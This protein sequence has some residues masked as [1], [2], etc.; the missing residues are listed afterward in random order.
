MMD[1]NKSREQLLEEVKE[2]RQQLLELEQSRKGS[3]NL[4]Q[5]L[6]TEKI[7]SE[8]VMESLPGIFYLF[9]EQGNMIRWNETLETTTHYSTEE[10]AR[11]HPLDFFAG[12]D[13]KKVESSIQQA[14]ASGQT[15]VEADLVGKNNGSIPFLFSGSRI[16]LDG[17]RFLVGLGIDITKRRLLEEAF[18]DLFLHAPI[19]IYIVQNRRLRMVNPGFQKITGYSEKELVGQDCLYLATDEFKDK[20]R[21]HA[22]QMLKGKTSTPYEYQFLTKGGEI[23]WAME[24]VVTTIYNGRKASIGYFMDITERKR[25]ENQLTQA[26]RMEAVGILAGGIAHD[27]NNLLT[28]IMGYGELMK[29]DLEKNDPHHHYTEEILKTATRG[30]SLTHQLLAFSRKQILQ[31]SVL[32][33]NSLVNNMEKL[34]R[35]LIGE[36]IELVTIIDPELGAIRA[37][38]GQIEQII[39]NLAVNARDAMPQGGKLTIETADVFLDETYGR[40]HLDVAPGPYVMLAVSDNGEGMDADTQSHIFEPFFTTKTMGQGTGLGLA[41]VYGIVKQSGG[42]IW[43]YSEPG[44]GTTFKIY[45]PRVEEAL[46]DT[47]AKGIT[48]TKLKGRETILVVEDDDTLREVIARGLKKFGYGVLTAGNGGE[49]LMVVEKRKGPIHLLLTDVVLPQMGGRE[50]AERLVALRPD[51]KVLYMSGYTEN[52]IVHHGILN[53]DVS[54]LQKPFKVNRMIVKIRE[55]LDSES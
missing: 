37:D 26:Q 3:E 34:L 53:D 9:N 47:E 41:T 23:K 5:N 46:S 16:N 48:V 27:F 24:S 54:F 38:K 13:I 12:E 42:H 20:I 40:T 17:Q 43:V 32:S 25:L 31:P 15:T 45:L 33:I 39:M 50:L 18:R 6:L 19:G 1:E 28:A 29:M 11:M 4:A 35:R 7:L 36:D 55:A 8:A 44:Q 22:V 52:A 21:Q 49:A 2:L 14:F 10:I 51:L 30:S